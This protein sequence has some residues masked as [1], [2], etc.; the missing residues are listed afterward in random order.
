MNKLL[1]KK[2]AAEEAVKEISSG[3]TIG[4]GSGSTVQFALA[5]IE[6]RIK[7]GDLKNIVGVPTSLH[8]EEVSK[9]LGIPVISLDEAV[10]RFTEDERRKSGEKI[11]PIDVTIDGADEVAVNYSEQ[12]A[13][14]IDLIKG[15]GGAML[16]EKIVAQATKRLIIIVDGSKISKQLGEKWS[17]PVEVIKFALAS[18]VAFL[19]SIGAKISVRKNS[20]GENYLTD[21]GN[22][23]VDA[24]F[25]GI[26]D[27]EKLTQLLDRRAGIVEHGIFVGLTDTV[28]CAEESGIRRINHF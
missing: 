4:L 5:A 10:E 18:E 25:G 6:E 26:N 9:Q 21:E 14:T 13:E 23:I 17:V 15:G 3:M 12:G 22:F 28:I 24:S 7:S 2:L 19:K 20:S 1:L 16:R 11:F 27:L 8:T